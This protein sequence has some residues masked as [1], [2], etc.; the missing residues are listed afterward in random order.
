MNWLGQALHVARKDVAQARWT[1]GAY[2]LLIGGGISL[3]LQV[4]PSGRLL[5]SE[6]ATLLL[7]PLGMFALATVVQADSPLESDA[8]WATRPLHPLAVFGAK[9]LVAG[10]VL[11]GAGLLGQLVVLLAHDVPRADLL[12]LLGDTAVVYAPWLALA[13]LAAA[14]TKDARSFIVTVIFAV[15]AMGTLVTLA[16]S[17]GPQDPSRGLT[18]TWVLLAALVTFLAGAAAQYRLRDARLGR[19]LAA[20][21]AAVAAFLLMYGPRTG[22]PAPPEQQ[23]VTPEW[24]RARL[25]SG[26]PDRQAGALQISL[27]RVHAEDGRMYILLRPEVWLDRDGRSERVPTLQSFARL[28]AHVSTSAETTPPGE[29][30]PPYEHVEELV[31]AV[32]SPD[33]MNAVRGGAGLRLRGLVEVRVPEPLLELPLRAGAH[34]ARNGHRVQVVSVDPGAGPVVARTSYVGR[35]NTANGLMTMIFMATATVE[36][37]LYNAR[38]QERRRLQ[39]HP[40]GGGGASLL[41]PGPDS[42]TVESDVSSVSFF[43]GAEADNYLA[44][45]RAWRNDAALHVIAWA[46]AGTMMVEVPVERPPPVS[47]R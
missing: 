9:L 27:S 41:L 34:A 22:V 30:L 42:W 31:H 11:L 7:I 19:P 39:T 17:R 29:N 43:A 26:L 36:Y 33:Q 15:L 21:A 2:A 37:E 24:L 6:A 32:L 46:P 38:L 28:S 5:S 20:G 1:V 16:A 12:P 3:V 4:L 45:E 18:S 13:A 35:R 10:V 47:R 25:E 23:A 44:E 40:R 8:F 14:V